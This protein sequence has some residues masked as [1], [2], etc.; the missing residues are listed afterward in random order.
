MSSSD[1]VVESQLAESSS[2][3][4]TSSTKLKSNQVVPFGTLAKSSSSGSSSDDV[5]TVNES[6]LSSADAL[7]AK[8]ISKIIIENENVPLTTLPN[9]QPAPRPYRFPLRCRVYPTAL[10]CYTS[11]N[12]LTTMCMFGSFLNALMEDWK[13]PECFDNMG[14]YTVLLVAGLALNAILGGVMCLYTGFL[15]KTRAR[16]NVSRMYLGRVRVLTVTTEDKIFFHLAHFMDAI[17]AILFTTELIFMPYAKAYCD[18]GYNLFYVTAT[19]L[20]A[21]ILPRIFMFCVH[22]KV[23]NSRPFYKWLKR[24][25]PSILAT[26]EGE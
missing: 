24:V 19:I 25:F 12:S 9:G 16:R 11:W 22:F 18:S 21:F 1:E 14:L 4:N 2:I 3:N 13:D 5:V 6:V 17:S 7:K 23:R 8:P 10:S 15:W 20:Q 26:V